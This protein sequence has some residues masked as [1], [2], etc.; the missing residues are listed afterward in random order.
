[1]PVNTDPQRARGSSFA[2]A[3]GPAS[4]RSWP[5][6]WSSTQIGPSFI[7]GRLDVAHYKDPQLR[8][9]LP[10]PDLAA[11]QFKPMGD[12]DTQLHLYDKVL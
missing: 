10:N 4:W 5:A 3:G 1:M 8:D 7:R 9:N 11:T 2:V 6:C 12:Y